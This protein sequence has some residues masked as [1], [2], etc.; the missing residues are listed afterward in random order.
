MARKHRLVTDVKDDW[1]CMNMAK[2]AVFIAAWERK[3]HE[4]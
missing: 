4:F 3:V 1:S 2:T